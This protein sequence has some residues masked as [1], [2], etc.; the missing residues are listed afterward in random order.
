MHRNTL[1]FISFLAVVAALLFGFNL[2]RRWY[3]PSPTPTPLPTSSPQVKAPTKLLTYINSICGIS[4][5]YPDT[6]TKLEA[7]SGAMF[8]DSQNASNSVALAC[9]AEIP[10]P[11]LAP[12]KVETVTLE[13]TSGASISAKLYHD[14]SSKDGSPIDELIFTHPKTGLDVFIA[15]FGAT[16]KQILNSLKIL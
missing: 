14:A 16:F 1:L 3:A 2:G 5:Q 11:P 6:L 13:A 9:Q 8:V 4:F 12:E 15:G 10:R 7:T